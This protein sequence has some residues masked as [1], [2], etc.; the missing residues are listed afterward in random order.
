MPR[1]GISKSPATKK[2]EGNRAKEGQ[3]DIPQPIKMKGTPVMPRT[4]NNDEKRLWAFV[5]SALPVDLLKK[6]DSPILER[7]VRAWHRYDCI[8]AAIEKYGV[9]IY[10]D[11]KKT[12][13]V[14]NPLIRTAMLYAKEMDVCG[15]QIGLSPSARNRLVGSND[16]ED[17]DDI[18]AAL[19]GGPDGNPTGAWFTEPETKQ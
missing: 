19:L 9:L 17:E 16:L 15:S 13:P 6:A 12:A 14:P 7:F 1:G 3:K 10:G 11:D 18:M 2:A 4:L 5:M 8:Q